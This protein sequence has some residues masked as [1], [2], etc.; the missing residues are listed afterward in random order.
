M[1]VHDGSQTLPRDQCLF[2]NV[3][4]R[5]PSM[6][7]LPPDVVLEPSHLAIEISEGDSI[8]DNGPLLA[9]ITQWRREGH[10][11][12]LDDYGTG[13]AAAATVL[14]VQPHLVKI[15]RSLLAGIDRDQRRQS[16]VAA[17]RTFTA[18]LGI[19]L[20]AEGIETSGELAVVREMGIELGQG[21]LL[22]RP[23]ARPVTE[24]LP[25][26][27]HRSGHP[28]LVEAPAPGASDALAFYA[29]A[30]ADSSVPTYLVDRRRRVVA[31]NREATRLTGYEASAMRGVPCYARGLQ[32]EDADGRPL[33]LT[34]CPLVWSMVKQ[35]PQS[36]VVSLETKSG[37]R[38][39]VQV[40][41][42]PVWD[43]A[44]H[45]VVGAIEQFQELPL[46][47]KGAWAAPMGR[48]ARGVSA[49]PMRGPRP[50]ARS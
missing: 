13:Y 34:A 14:A 10:L 46:V 24:S 1:A 47:A 50:S 16:L 8:L 5:W 11:I 44:T 33:C 3:E 9:A 37:T 19:R 6:P 17:I 4:G 42:M 12:V 43:T 45:R 27:R 7:L 41:A 28:F 39:I 15:D 36:D 23:L 18:D 30:I 20:V 48:G 2:M 21:F 35:R 25:M 32:H 26:P 49:V 40:L 38:R 31:W 29:E 22:G